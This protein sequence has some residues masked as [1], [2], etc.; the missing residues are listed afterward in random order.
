MTRAK[1]GEPSIDMNGQG[2]VDSLISQTL[3][4]G[5]GAKLTD[6]NTVVVK[7]TGWLTNGKQFDSSWDRDSTIDADLFSDSS[8]QHQVIEGWQKV[9]LVIPPDQAYGDKEQGP[10]PANSTLVFVI[11]ILAAY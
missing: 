11:D 6:K 2:S 3:I 1:N 5:N 9:L 4:K 7:Y 10:I 8:G